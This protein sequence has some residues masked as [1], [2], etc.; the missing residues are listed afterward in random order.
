MARQNFFHKYD[1][2]KPRYILHVH[3]EELRDDLYR[4]IHSME[5]EQSIDFADVLTIEVANPVS[6]ASGARLFTD[7]RMFL[8]GNPIDVYIG[9]G[10][11]MW[12]LGRCYVGKWFPSF[13]EDGIPTLK[14]KAY[15]FRMK[16]ARH[17]RHTGYTYNKKDYDIA[18]HVATEHWGLL[19]LV[20]PPPNDRIRARMHKRGGN[21]LEF[22]NRL[23]HLNNFE[24]FTFFSIA[25]NV[26]KF[27]FGPSDDPDHPFT[28]LLPSSIYSWSE[29]DEV[30]RMDPGKLLSFEP[31]WAV[32]GQS[33]KVIISYFDH[34]QEKSVSLDVSA[35]N[36]PPVS[37]YIGAEK[38]KPL[39][40]ELKSGVQVTLTA[41]GESQEVVAD[42]PINSRED[43]RLFAERWFL[44]R[45]NNFIVGEGK[46]VGEP[47]FRPKQT[48]YLGNLGTRF[49][50]DYYVT[51]VKHCF[52]GEGIY[53][54]E[55]NCRKKVLDK[56]TTRTTVESVE[57]E[58]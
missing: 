9:Y 11:S 4:Y 48:H 44:E 17:A 16:M 25:D 47:R 35:L 20:R 43:A 8:E 12:F 1:Y 45:M 24:F 38:F 13:P 10:T 22:M 29:Q 55:F 5:Y 58:E 7:S 46:I 40:K 50:G 26:E 32:H 18:R 51:R 34:G 6:D 14:I 15:D 21:D 57:P 2:L 19:P 23:A 3:G 54:T 41:F 27:Y 31:N 52:E 36:A 42:I 37:E 28:G 53:Y 39:R 56:P 33:S 49:R 30:D